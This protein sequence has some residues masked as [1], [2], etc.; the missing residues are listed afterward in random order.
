M[1]SHFCGEIGENHTEKYRDC[2]MPYHTSTQALDVSSI[3]MISGCQTK[4]V[5]II[6]WHSS[7]ASFDVV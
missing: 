6:R 2:Y 4:K 5:D 3:L 1:H 7:F